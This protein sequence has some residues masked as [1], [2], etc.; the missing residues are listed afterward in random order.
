MR[1]FKMIKV[2]KVEN[3]LVVARSERWEKRRED[4][5]KKAI[6]RI[7]VVMEMFCNLNVSMSIFWL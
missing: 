1:F 2:I 5:Y 3:R 6:R 4:G 7:L